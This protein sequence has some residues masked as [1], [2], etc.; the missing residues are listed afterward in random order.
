MGDPT[1]GAVGGVPRP[2]DYRQSCS[3]RTDPVLKM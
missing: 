1:A 3:T 2:A